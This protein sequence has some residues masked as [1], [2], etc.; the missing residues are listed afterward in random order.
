M[1][2]RMVRI[3]PHAANKAHIR[4][5]RPDRNAPYAGN[6]QTA[7]PTEGL[8]IQPSGRRSVVAALRNIRGFAGE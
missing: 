8:S 5:T 2:V 6:G 4:Q 1:P 7:V 3:I